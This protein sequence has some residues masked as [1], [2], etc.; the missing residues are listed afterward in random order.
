MK[1][2]LAQYKVLAT[3]E[4][5]IP[6]VGPGRYRWVALDLDA[7]GAWILNT[8]WAYQTW[9]YVQNYGRRLRGEEMREVAVRC[10][11]HLAKEKFTP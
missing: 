11:P 1:T 9:W 7:A 10:C 5:E 6:E 8:H 2:R 4:G 3:G